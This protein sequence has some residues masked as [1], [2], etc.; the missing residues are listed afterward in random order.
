MF[1]GRDGSEYSGKFKRDDFQFYADFIRNCFCQFNIGA[2]ILFFPFFGR[3]DELIG[4][5]VRFGCDFNITALFDFFQTVFS[6]DITTAGGTAGKCGGT[7][8][9]GKGK[10]DK[11]AEVLH[12]EHPFGC[13]SLFY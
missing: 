7:G 8:Q 2:D 10:S 13:S 6:L 9:S 3:V 12:I 1:A 11:S 4:C 5:E